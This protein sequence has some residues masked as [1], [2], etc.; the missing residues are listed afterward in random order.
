[1]QRGLKVVQVDDLNHG[2]PVVSMQRG[3]KATLYTFFCTWI[4]LMS[5]CKE[6]WKLCILVCYQVLT[7]ICLNAKRIE[8][9][10]GSPYVLPVLSQS[11]CKEDWKATGFENIR[12]CVSAV[13]MQRG[14]KELC[15]LGVFKFHSFR[16]QCKEDWK[17][18]LKVAIGLVKFLSQ[19]KEDWK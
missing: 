3:L 18:I 9:L 7:K 8:S 15:R 10:W 6:D 16:S 2:V 19:C 5:Q 12:G 4:F 14:L 11:Q 1:M 13:S 17:I